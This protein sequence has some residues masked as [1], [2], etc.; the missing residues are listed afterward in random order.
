MNDVKRKLAAY[1]WAYA[2]NDPDAKR[3]LANRILEAARRQK[4]ISYSDLVKGVTFR[5]SN[6]NGGRPFEIIDW[7]DLHRAII[8]DFLGSISA[9]SYSRAGVFFSAVVVTKDDGTPGPGF[10]NFMRELGVLSGSSQTAALECWVREVEKVYECC[11]K[12]N[13]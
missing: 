11:Q 8:G 5:L 10:T 9:D 4:L 3:V 6:V 7:T 13:P 1:Q 12:S 2:V